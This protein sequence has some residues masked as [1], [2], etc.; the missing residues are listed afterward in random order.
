VWRR[1]KAGDNIKGLP[2][3]TYSSIKI[4]PIMPRIY[5]I[6]FSPGIFSVFVL[7]REV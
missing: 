4:N 5:R 7:L 6:L 1:G 3:A 2:I